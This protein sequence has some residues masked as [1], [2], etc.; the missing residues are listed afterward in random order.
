[1]NTNKLLQEMQEGIWCGISHFEIYDNA[2]DIEW[3]SLL[4]ERIPTI[5]TSV[6]DFKNSFLEIDNVELAKA[7]LTALLHKGML[8]SM[9]LMPLDKANLLA[10][11]FFSLFSKQAL[12][13]SN[14]T[15]NEN[16]YAGPDKDFEFGLSSYAPLTELTFDSGIVICDN[17]KI[18]IIWFSEDD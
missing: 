3:Q 7:I 18:G 16:E 6:E 4:F 5:I 17:S 8:H 2:V 12:Y 14:S 11:K 13:F 15:W 1:M 9:E 10:D